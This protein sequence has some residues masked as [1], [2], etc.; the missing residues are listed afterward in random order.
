MRA[1]NHASIQRNMAI[2]AFS[3]C[4]SG[5]NTDFARSTEPAVALSEIA[6]ID[7]SV[8]VRGEA[9]EGYTYADLSDDGL[10]VEVKGGDGRAVVGFKAPGRKRGV[11]GARRLVE[12]LSWTRSANALKSMDDVTV[13]S[14][15]TLLPR[16]TVRIHSRSALAKIRRLQ[17]T[18]YVEPDALRE[19]RSS[20]FGCS[21]TPSTHPTI[22]LGGDFPGVD[23]MSFNYSD[24]YI[25]RA[26]AYSTGQGVNI[27]LVDTG[28]LGFAPDMSTDFATGM[29]S[30][31]TLTNISILGGST[32]CSHGVR[33]AGLLAAPRN[34]SGTIGVAWKANLIS[35][36]ALSTV[37]LG[38]NQ[39]TSAATAA[40]GI[41]LA[42]QN[43]AKVTV[44]AFGQATWSNVIGDEIALWSEENDIVYVGAAGTCG[45]DGAWFVTCLS[46]TAFPARMS[47]VF[48]VSGATWSGG[49]SSDVWDA[50]KIN[51]VA[52]IPLSSTGTTG[53]QL[54]SMGGS[55]AATAVIGGVAAL[56]RAKYFWW[57]RHQVVERLAHSV[58]VPCGTFLAWTNTLIN[59]EGAVGGVCPYL[60]GAGEIIFDR[61]DIDPRMTQ[62]SLYSIQ[63][64]GDNAKR[65]TWGDGS[66]SVASFFVDLFDNHS[67]TFGRGNYETDV[68]AD[69]QDIEMSLPPRRVRMR[70]RVIDRDTDPNCPTCF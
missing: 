41:R 42:A 6:S 12:K 66:T 50:S 35:V 31:R 32:S 55:S 13:E 34:G 37:F 29:S 44:M 10:W 11:Y 56:V 46:M 21:I 61:S 48:S 58:G 45:T 2:L 1:A 40:A 67:V 69:V 27:G 57:N 17:T 65:V 63:V 24:M 53:T 15:D 54:L 68:F 36:H 64:R 14:I 4:A 43:G 8:P 51:A 26:W 18:D 16:A 59:A 7:R 9:G 38:E 47:Q 33:M 3:V 62:S 22:A 49:M 52:T 5:C 28:I 19:M 23:Q 30:G 25:D 70:V 39:T 20:T 60:V